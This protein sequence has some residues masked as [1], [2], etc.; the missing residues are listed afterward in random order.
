MQIVVD[1]LYGWLQVLQGMP[2]HCSKERDTGLGRISGAMC[3]WQSPLQQLPGSSASLMPHFS[4]GRTFLLLC[5]ACPVPPARLWQLHKPLGQFALPR[6][7][8][9]SLGIYTELS[10]RAGSDPAR[11]R[12]FSAAKAPQ[13]Q[14]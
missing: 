5:K 3:C 1:L 6:K 11:G 10:V 2:L 4:T 8:E 13:R 7:W 9:G 12:N 14:H